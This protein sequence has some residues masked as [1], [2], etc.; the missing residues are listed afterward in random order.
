MKNILSISNFLELYESITSKIPSDKESLLKSFKKDVSQDMFAPTQ[1]FL[2]T[3]YNLLNEK[4]FNN[5]LPHNLIFIISNAPRA[6]YM[7]VAGYQINRFLEHVTPLFIKLN[8]SR[9]MT[10]H[11]WLEVVLHEMIHILD[12]QTNPSHFLYGNKKSYDS[13]GSWFL[14]KGKEFLSEGFNVQKYCNSYQELDLDNKTI[15]NKINNVRFILASIKSKQAVFV[16]SDKTLENHINILGEVS[17]YRVKDMKLQKILK[18]SNPDVLRLKSIRMKNYHSGY[19][20]YW[21]TEDFQNKYGPFEEISE[22]YTSNVH[23]DR[24][25]TD[26]EEMNH[27]DDQYARQIYNNITNVVDIKKLED[28]EYEVSIA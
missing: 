25:E 18:S 21:F 28:G 14:N 16:V 20:W 19:S 4:F 2:E 27:I 10:V 1:E 12:Y 17:K 9:K 26:Y 5:S 3:S 24:D 6:I 22:I 8:G 13:H 15:K 23:E 11:N 7:G